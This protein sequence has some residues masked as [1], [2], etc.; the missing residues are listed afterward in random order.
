MVARRFLRSSGECRG[1]VR[2][3]GWMRMT[4]GVRVLSTTLTDCPLCGNSSRLT[5]TTEDGA[6]TTRCLRCHDER[7]PAALPRI[8]LDDPAAELRGRRRPLSRPA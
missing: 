1:V 5:I 4:T 6:V 7:R 8:V 2:G 3:N